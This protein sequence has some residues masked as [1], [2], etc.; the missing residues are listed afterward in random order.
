M[1]GTGQLAAFA[2]LVGLYC[3]TSML[4][5]FWLAWRNRKGR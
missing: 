5:G 3:I 4:V 1:T 2:A